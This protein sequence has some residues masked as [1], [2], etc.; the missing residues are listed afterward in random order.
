MHHDKCSAFKS[1]PHKIFG[2]ALL[3]ALHANAIVSW[4]LIRLM[5]IVCVK[6]CCPWT[7]LIDASR[8]DNA[9]GTS[10]LF[11]LNCSSVPGV[12]VR[13]WK[14]A[15][16]GFS[17]RSWCSLHIHGTEYMLP[18]A[19]EEK[20]VPACMRFFCARRGP[21][22]KLLLFLADFAYLFK[23]HLLIA[24][25]LAGKIKTGG[26]GSSSIFMA[27]RT[28][29]GALFSRGCV[30]PHGRH[31]GRMQIGPVTRLSMS[32]GRCIRLGLFSLFQH[33]CGRERN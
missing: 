30:M 7:I 14:A 21:I 2:P 13:A 24:M 31:A 28:L 6:V 22:I 16:S 9:S 12:S 27:G 10:K 32:R 18:L 26:G 8:H 11:I 1:P 23:C 17:F 4:A 3:T 29:A 15:L 25:R 5:R 33:K 20:I 19:D